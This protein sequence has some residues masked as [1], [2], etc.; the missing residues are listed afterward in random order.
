MKH[1]YNI[2]F[3]ILFV[4]AFMMQSW[5]GNPDRQG[6][7]GAYELLM[8]PWARSAGFSGMNIANTTGVESMRINVAGLSRINK[9]EVTL[10]YT[11]YLTATNTS[12]TAFG[13]AQKVGK[14][15][16]FGLNLTSVGF[17]DIRVTTTDQPDGTGATFS[18]TF[19]NIGLGYSHMFENKV[20]VGIIMRAVSEAMSDVNGIGLA[21]DAGVQYVT[22]PADNFK[23]GLSL[24]NM[25]TKMRFSG[26]GLSVKLD[27]D[28]DNG[29]NPGIILKQDAAAFELPTQLNI[30]LSND[31]YLGQGGD[32][33]A[34]TSHRL[35]I[36]ASFT[37]N[38]FSRDQVG[39]GLEYSFKER[40]MVRGAYEIEVG[41]EEGVDINNVYDGLSLG[42]T[43][44]LPMNK[45]NQSN[46]MYFN[47]AYRTTEVFDGTHNFGVSISL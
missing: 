25:G 22:G 8:L 43:V 35:T 11:D 46:M 37:G 12:I 36:L 45:K 17:G 47:Y 4:T 10:G 27:P 24:R 1:L 30:G 26:Q 19:F 32:S 39:G 3:I 33:E 29:Q 40:F 41:S 42:A 28:G 21:I 16:T 18:P 9:T 15:G 31:F 38:S 14:S 5:A 2:S 34:V 6:E 13:V 23:F 20:S 7:A 44:A